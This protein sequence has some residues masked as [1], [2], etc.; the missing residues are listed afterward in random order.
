MSKL[1]QL[2]QAATLDACLIVRDEERNLPGCLESLLA[3]RP[4]LGEINVYDTGSSDRTMEIARRAGCRVVQGA[5]HNDFAKA[6]NSA[7]SMSDADWALLIDAD[8]RVLADVQHLSA[9]LAS[10]TSYD[11]INAALSHLDDVGRVIGRSDYEKVVRVGR[12]EFSGRI[13]ETVRRFDGQP[14][15]V[16]ALPDDVLHFRHLGY[17]TAEVRTAKAQR[18]ASVSRADIAAAT[19]SGDPWWVG[20]SHYHYARSLQRLGVTEEALAALKTAQS[21]FPSGSIARDRVVSAQ[22]GL[23]LESGRSTEAASV[24]GTHLASGGATN[25]V[26]LLLAR[27]ALHAHRPGDALACLGQIPEA[28]DPEHEVD[29]RDVLRLQIAALDLLGRRDESLACCLVLVT[30]WA[31]L[32]HVQDLL[33]RVEGQEAGVVAALLNGNSAASAVLLE[34]LRRN[35]A[36]GQEVASCLG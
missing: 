32:V 12:V 14:V 17:A 18:N 28:G 16:A 36:F 26:R 7:L 33:G 2:R 23:L 31:D 19:E 15:R 24:V 13:H 10:F 35:G 1:G 5:W 34:E 20:Q 8:E 27:I 30:R 21:A 3:M 25:V 11:V 4:T 9:I 29:P 22:V 6:R